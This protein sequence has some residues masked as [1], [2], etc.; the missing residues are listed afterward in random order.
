MGIDQIAFWAVLIFVGVVL[1][2]LPAILRAW[3][4]ARK[5]DRFMPDSSVNDP[6][7]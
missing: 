5:S 7:K 1:P 2:A 4:T 3:R 6:E